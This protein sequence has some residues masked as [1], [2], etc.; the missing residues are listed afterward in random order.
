MS[1]KTKVC[2]TRLIRKAFAEVLI[3]DD[4]WNLVKAANECIKW[5]NENPHLFVEPQ[6]IDVEEKD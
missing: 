1:P 3:A 4:P 2:R 5:C 6:P